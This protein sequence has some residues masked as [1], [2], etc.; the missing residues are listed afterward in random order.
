M[1]WTVDSAWTENRGTT[2]GWVL[3]VSREAPELGENAGISTQVFLPSSVV[4]D[5]VEAAQ[6]DMK[7]RSFY[8]RCD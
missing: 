1:S 3:S 7:V 8:S 4:V 6:S 5:L 2:E